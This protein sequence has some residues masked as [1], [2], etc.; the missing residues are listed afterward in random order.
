[1]TM[2]R[3]VL[4]QCEYVTPSGYRCDRETTELSDRWCAIHC[5]PDELDLSGFHAARV[6][7]AKYVL[8]KG[9]PSAA[10]TLVRLSGDEEAGAGAN[11]KAATEVMDRAGIPRVAATVLQA[12]ITHR[13]GRTAAQT[14]RERLSALGDRFAETEED[15]LPEPPTPLVIEPATEAEMA[16]DGRNPLAEGDGTGQLSLFI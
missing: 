10:E 13:E 11:I 7:A 14:V 3:T 9:L 15:G 8:A 16:A 2:A 1:M 12:D 4:I 6:R 5:P